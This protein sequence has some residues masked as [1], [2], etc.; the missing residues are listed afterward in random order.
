MQVSAA[1]NATVDFSQRTY[2]GDSSTVALSGTS[3]STLRL[4]F[5]TTLNRDL[6]YASANNFLGT[7]NVQPANSS[8][9]QLVFETVN[10]SYSSSTTG[11]FTGLPGT[12]N[13]NGAVSAAAPLAG[14]HRWRSA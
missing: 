11:G 9:G 4:N 2:F 7:L 10:G 12:F 14:G 8:G 3:T 6:F 5:G 1:T 13:V